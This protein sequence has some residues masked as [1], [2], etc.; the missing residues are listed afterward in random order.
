MTTIFTPGLNALVTELRDYKIDGAPSSLFHD[1]D[2]QNMR[3]ALSLLDVFLQSNLNSGRVG[4]STQVILYA[5]L[6]YPANQIAEV[7][8]DGTPANN[9]TYV[10]VGATGTGSWTQVSALSLASLSAVV[11]AAQTAITSEIAS[12][13]AG[14]DVAGNGSFLTLYDLPVIDNG[15]LRIPA[16][17]I[18]LL[19]GFY[20]DVAPASGLYYEVDVTTATERYNT[21][22]VIYYDTADNNIHATNAYTTISNL[23]TDTR[24]IICYVSN[25]I[26]QGLTRSARIVPNE[27]DGSAD[28][29]PQFM[30]PTTTV[31]VGAVTAPLNAFYIYQAYASTSTASGASISVSGRLKT[32]NARY[33]FARV[34]VFD[35][36]ATPGTPIVPVFNTF[37]AAYTANPGTGL[38]SRGSGVLEKVHSTSLCSYIIAVKANPGGTFGVQA[39]LTVGSRNVMLGGL[40]LAGSIDPNIY[41][42][43][44][45]NL[46]QSGD[47]EFNDFPRMCMGK[48]LAFFS[49]RAFTIYPTNLLNRRPKNGAL[50]TLSSDSPSTSAIPASFTGAHALRVDPAPWAAG[51]AAT[52]TYHYDRYLADKRQWLPLTMRKVTG[53]ALSGKTIKLLCIGDSLTDQIVNIQAAAAILTAYGATVTLLGTL[54][55][56]TAPHEGRSGKMLADYVGQTKANM[57]TT[58]PSAYTAASNLSRYGLNPFLFSGSGTGSYGGYIFDFSQFLSNYKS[59]WGGQT[60][61]IVLVNLRTND[62]GVGGWANVAQLST[63]MASASSTVVT[64]IRAAGPKVLWWAQ[65]P[66][67]HTFPNELF[68]R[69]D[70]DGAM[71]GILRT[72]NGI[73]DYANVRFSS[74]FAQQSPFAFG[75]NVSTFVDADT[76]VNLGTLNDPIHFA[77]SAKQEMAQALAADIAF[78]TP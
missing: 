71:R 45:D 47:F 3:S 25:G 73:G 43:T 62:I 54:N 21:A 49:D 8:A 27:F 34:W 61:D 69:F 55:I 66:S 46:G 41:I 77:Q 35:A 63:F 9:G 36:D 57:A 28:L 23:G 33:I 14:L 15:T 7:F 48:E 56:G 50:I 32:Q 6:G 38:T 11:S 75:A 44:A 16:L 19:T 68:G 31:Q 72:V 2:K 1:P 5:S 52:L 40:Q 60:P 22:V 74:V 76:G 10:K 13:V 4:F 70:F 67:W 26:I 51:E 58:T 12:R 53:S 64:S 65:A 20:S 39:G 37:T 18:R 59:L 78:M 17:H 24:R 42:S 29:P 30:G